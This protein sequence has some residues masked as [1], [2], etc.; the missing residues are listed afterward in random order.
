M[1]V[2]ELVAAVVSEQDIFMGTV[3]TKT[4]DV[5]LL[6]SGTDYAQVPSTSVLGHVLITVPLL[7]KL[8]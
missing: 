4:G 5:L 1:D 3:V 2:N 6:K 7:G 8:F